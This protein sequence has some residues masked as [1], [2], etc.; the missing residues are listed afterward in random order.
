MFVSTVVLLLQ[1]SAHSAL[2]S[3]ESGV[4]GLDRRSHL[5][6]YSARDPALGAGDIL[7]M[8]TGRTGNIP[9]LMGSRG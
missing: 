8:T 6:E 1:S 2:W 9:H 5:M 7:L 3:L 4:S